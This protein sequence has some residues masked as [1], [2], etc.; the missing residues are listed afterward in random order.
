MSTMPFSRTGIC[1]GL[2]HLVLR[3]EQRGAQLRFCTHSAEGVAPAGALVGFGDGCA[4]R[5]VLAGGRATHDQLPGV[6]HVC[7]RGNTMILWSAAVDHSPNPKARLNAPQH[8]VR[9]PLGG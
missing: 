5:E 9:V 8:S 6:R 7:W 1:H 4:Y 3:R 2:D